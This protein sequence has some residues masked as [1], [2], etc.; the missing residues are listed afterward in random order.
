M[1]QFPQML[2]K[3]GNEIKL[4]AGTFDTKIVGDEAEFEQA[5]LEGWFETSTAA[6]EAEA[7]AKAA[8]D[9]AKAE[10]A[11]QADQ[12]PEGPAT[13]RASL[14]ARATAANVPFSARVSD[15]KLEAA[16]LEAEAAAKQDQ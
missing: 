2:Y 12:Q 9:A 16:V 13:D 8:A 7:A 6:V 10:A 15:K 3:L 11:K 4:D 5:I 14:E 1:S